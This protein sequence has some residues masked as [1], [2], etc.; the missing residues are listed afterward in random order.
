MDYEWYMNLFK[1]KMK[2]FYYYSSDNYFFTN[3]TSICEGDSILWQNSYYNT[4]GTYTANYLTVES[5]DSTYQLNLTVYPRP[6]PFDISGLDF[7]LQGHTELYTVPENFDVTYN[8]LVESSEIITYPNENSAEIQWISVGEVYI[9]SIAVDSNGCK[10]DTAELLVNIGI[11]NI[12]DFNNPDEINIYPNPVKDFLFIS[13]PHEYQVEIIDM[14]GRKLLTTGKNEIDVSIIK[15]GTYI[16]RFKD[17]QGNIIKD[18]KLIK[19]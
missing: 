2:D 7:S 13:T 4:A 6:L 19:E 1:I 11:N 10:S 12:H 9:Y 18:E 5:F 17:S 15:R 3:N 14:M 16:L 8:W